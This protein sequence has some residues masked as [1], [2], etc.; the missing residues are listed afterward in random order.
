[1]KYQAWLLKLLTCHH[2]PK[3]AHAGHLSCLNDTQPALR[4]EIMGTP[5]RPSTW[6]TPPGRGARETREL[7]PP[8][9]QA[10]PHLELALHVRA[11][12]R[13]GHERPQR[14]VGVGHDSQGDGPRVHAVHHLR[15]ATPP[16][17]TPLACRQRVGCDV[18]DVCDAPYVLDIHDPKLAHT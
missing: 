7:A 9:K 17:S 6:A 10:P 16:R 14:L 12:Q 13:L 8:P 11:V 1:M 3:T 5:A 15:A 2:V 4:L 18:R